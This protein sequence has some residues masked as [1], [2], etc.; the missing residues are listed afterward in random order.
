MAHPQLRLHGFILSLHRSESSRACTAVCLCSLL[1]EAEAQPSDEEAH[2]LKL[3]A[4][5]PVETAAQLAAGNKA[6]ASTG[7]SSTAA[8][9]PLAGEH[10]CPVMHEVTCYTSCVKIH[11]C[12]W[13]KSRSN[14][15]RESASSIVTSEER[16]VVE[17]ILVFE[18]LQCAYM[19]IR[20]SWRILALFVEVSR[21]LCSNT[22]V[23]EVS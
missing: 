17:Q 20:E 23:L 8:V 13:L 3:G 19:R 9:A 16:L 18:V 7:L 11:A 1:A 15:R 14:I 10:A 2:S 4:V 5:T 6:T 22:P 12:T 21:I